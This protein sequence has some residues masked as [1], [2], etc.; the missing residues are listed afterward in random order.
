MGETEVDAA[1]AI[2]D[3]HGDLCEDGA[4]VAASIRGFVRL[5]GPARLTDPASSGRTAP[6]RSKKQFHEVVGLIGS[7]L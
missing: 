4:A 5:H 2:S 6:E 1:G 3:R 7:S